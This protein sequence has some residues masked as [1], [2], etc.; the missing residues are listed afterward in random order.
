MD[1]GVSGGVRSMMESADK[2]VL[3]ESSDF[4]GLIEEWG[5]FGA[6]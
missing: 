3:G 6:N 5:E 2:D 1:F 4:D